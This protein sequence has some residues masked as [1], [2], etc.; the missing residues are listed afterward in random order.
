MDISYKY[1]GEQWVQHCKM[2]DDSDL[3]IMNYDE[4]S[5][6]VISIYNY[7]TGKIV[8][9]YVKVNDSKYP[10]SPL[11]VKSIDPEFEIQFLVTKELTESIAPGEYYAEAKAV[12]SGDEM[13]ITKEPTYFFTLRPS[14][15]K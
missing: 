7:D 10:T 14:K 8:Q 6:I 15:T 12:I 3:S 1:K 2:I 5:Q 13:P 9:D 11:L 4:C